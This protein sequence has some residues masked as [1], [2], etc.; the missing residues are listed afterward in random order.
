[1]VCPTQI[2]PHRILS[3][4]FPVSKYLILPLSLTKSHGF[5]RQFRSVPKPCT[6][7]SPRESELNHF[8]AVVRTLDCWIAHQRMVHISS[9]NQLPS[10]RLLFSPIPTHSFIHKP[11]KMYFEP[12]ASLS[13]NLSHPSIHQASQPASSRSQSIH[14]FIH[15]F[16]YSIRSAFI[17]PSVRQ[18]DQQHF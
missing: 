15:S 9:L 12:S 16:I 7:Q 17:Q 10:V 2:S 6:T 4:Q 5:Q 1:M 8:R 3:N 18:S 13:G 14:S 11:Y